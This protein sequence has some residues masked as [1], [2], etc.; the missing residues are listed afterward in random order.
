MGTRIIDEFLAKSGV[1][2]CSGFKDACETCAKVGAET[3]STVSPH[4]L[5][6]SRVFL[7][8]VGFQMFLGVVADIP[9]GSWN[10]TFTECSVILPD[11]PLIEAALLSQ[12]STRAMRSHT[13]GSAAVCGAP[14]GV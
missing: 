8:Q 7:P 9:A 12:N 14:R 4:D 13:A 5:L 10:Q 11:N 1:P 2:Q 6:I 3:T